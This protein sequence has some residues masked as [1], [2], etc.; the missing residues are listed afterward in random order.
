MKTR[1][2]TAAIALL[3]APALLLAQ[4][5][6]YD[7]DKAANFADKQTKGKYSNQINQAKHKVTEVAG[8]QNTPN[9][10]HHPAVPPNPGV[11]ADRSPYSAPGQERPSPYKRDG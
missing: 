10:P 2:A 8:V 3:L 11:P 1:L 4:K 7:Y 9:A 5:V 6:S